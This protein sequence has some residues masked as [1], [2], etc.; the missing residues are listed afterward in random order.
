MSGFLIVFLNIVV[1]G[2]IIK[3]LLPFVELKNGE[4]IIPVAAGLEPEMSA[5]FPLGKQENNYTMEVNVKVMD[6]YMLSTETSFVVR[7]S[8]N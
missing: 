2:D 7:V 5:R 6:H 4:E 8:E 3:L 1:V